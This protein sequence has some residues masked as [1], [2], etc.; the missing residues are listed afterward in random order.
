MPPSGGELA[1]SHSGQPLQGLCGD[2]QGSFVHCGQLAEF[3]Q[4]RDTLATKGHWF[5]LMGTAK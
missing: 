2:W 3:S 5:S 1:A 4:R